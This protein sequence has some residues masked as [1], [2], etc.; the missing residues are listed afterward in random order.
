MS[1]TDLFERL[2]ASLHE[3]VLDDAHW[4]SASALVDE[5]CGSKGNI[6][7]SSEGGLGHDAAIF[8]ARVCYRGQR[9]EEFETEY[10]RVYHHRDERGP[11]LRQLPD[12][13]IV[14]VEALYTDE[15]KRRSVAY[16]EML[17]R[18]DTGNCLHARLD[19][20]HGSRII[21]TAADPV[22][23]AGWSSQ[24]VETLAR[25]LPHIR[26]YVRV[27]LALVNARAVGSTMTE[28]LEVNRC[29][30]IQLDPRGRIVA[31]NDRAHQM[32][33]NGEALSDA[34]GCLRARIP[35]ED[36]KLQ[37]LLARALP[38]FGAGGV[39]GSMTVTP[40]AD[41]PPRLVLH[42]SPV[43]AGRPD[44]R[45][46]RVGAIVLVVEP[47]KRAT[48]DP[49]LVADALGL[50]PTETRVAVMLAAGNTV[51]DIARATGRTKGTVGWHLR[52]IFEK[53]RISRQVELVQLIRSLSAV[54]GTRD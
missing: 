17:A 30:V 10:F 18:S 34:K 49:E 26:Q 20:P 21:W 50:T 47:E 43:G 1:G 36:A 35:G 22:D 25:L 45:A 4:P 37:S 40:S 31:A 41:S 51:G 48:A 15:E 38:R 6:L 9:H 32:L 16:N 8:F 54:A 11:R 29:G 14:S 12:S 3:A 27:R 44:I 28:L 19:G 7:I 5:A 2:L 24:R 52:Q 39:S 33:R 53:N 46:N 23:D 42:V 13:K